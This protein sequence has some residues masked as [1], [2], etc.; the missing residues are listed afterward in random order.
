M[1]IVN[2]ISKANVFGNRNDDD[3]ADRLVIK[4]DDLDLNVF[5]F[6]RRKYF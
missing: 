1:D 3:L 5:N 2:Y 4:S 6:K